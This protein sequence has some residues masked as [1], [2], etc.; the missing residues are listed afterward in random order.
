MPD[1]IEVLEK[2]RPL[3]QVRTGKGVFQKVKKYVC[4]RTELYSCLSSYVI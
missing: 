4:G 3:M 1:I 2:E